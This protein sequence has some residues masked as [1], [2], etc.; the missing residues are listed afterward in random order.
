MNGH[1]TVYAGSGHGKTSAA[2]GVAVQAASRGESVAVIMFMKAS[3]IKDSEFMG[4]LEPEI[5]LFHFEKSDCDYM[6]LPPEKKEEEIQNI[7]NGLNYAK[8]VLNTGE[9]DL[10]ILDEVLGLLDNGIITHEDLEKMLSGK[11]TGTSVIM[12]GI[13]LDDEIC[14]MAD[15]VSKIETVK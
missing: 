10:V 12:T 14:R 7:K 5:R 11:A 13:H 2:L 9:C 8:K 3:Q 15:E 4:R 6:N 1:I